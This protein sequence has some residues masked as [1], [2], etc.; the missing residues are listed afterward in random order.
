MKYSELFSINKNFQYSV[1][2]EFDLNNKKKIEEYIPTTDICDVLKTYVK[3]V[4][5]HSKDKATTLVGPY[6]KGKSFLLL[7]LSYILEL[8]DK[9]EI[10]KLLLDKIKFIDSELYDLI[11][12]IDDRAIKLLPV[13]INSNYDNV[14]QSFQLALNDALKRNKLDDIIPKTVYDVCTSLLNKWEKDP[15][16]NNKVLKTCLE[17]NKIDIKDLKKGLKYFSV[18]AYKK[19]EILYNCVNI[20]LEFNP[21][22]SNDIVKIYADV[23]YQLP[24][25]GY[26]GLFIIF[27]EFSKFLDGTSSLMRD[28]KIIQDFAEL[29]DRSSKNEQIHLCCVT[30]KSFNLYQKNKDDSVS[31]AFKTVEGRFKEIKFN[32][33]LEENYQIISYAIKRKN[34]DEIVSKYINDNKDFYSEIMNLKIVSD[35]KN[36]DILINGCFPLNP[37]TVYSLIQLSEIVAQNERT[38]FTFLSDTDANSFNSFIH[39]HDTGLFNV[40]KIYDYFSNLLRKEETNYIRNIWYRCESTLSKLDDNVKRSIIKTI[41]IIHMINDFEKLSPSNEIIALCLNM[42]VEEIKIHID[43]LMEIRLIKRNF[44]NNLLSFAS[45]NSKEIEEEL[46]KVI[47]GKVKNIR[48]SEIADEINEN[49]YLLPRRYNEQNKITRFFKVIFL[50]DSE[51]IDLINFDNLMENLYCDGIVIYLIKRKIS[52]KEIIEKMNLINDDRVIVKYPVEKVD[53]FFVDELVKFAGLKEINSSGSI[54]DIVSAEINLILEETR[55]DIITLINN[56]F[57]DNCHYYH[58]N[59]LELSFNNLLSTVM[60]NIY[61]RI[62]IFNNELINKTNVSAQYQKSIN[63]VIDYLINFRTEFSFSETSPEMTIYN[64]VILKSEEADIREAINYIKNFIIEAEGTKNSIRNIVNYLN[65]RPFGIRLGI[66]PILIG[67]AINELSDNV[68]LYFQNKEIDLTPENIVKSVY[69]ENDKYAF[70]FARGSKEQNIYLDNLMNLFKVGK[71]ENFRFDINA[72]ADRIRKWFIGLPQIIRS[73]NAS[74]N[75]LN[76]SDEIL[77]LKYAYMSFNINPYE[78]VFTKPLKLFKTNN[79]EQVYNA[80]LDFVENIDKVLLTYKQKL[81]I[82]LKPIFEVTNDSSLKTGINDWLVKKINLK[83]TPILEGIHRKI[84]DCLKDSLTYDDFQ[85][86]DQVAKAALN[87]YIEDWDNDRSE[88]LIAVMSEFSKSISSSKKINLV[89]KNGNLESILNAMS[90]ADETQMGQLLTNSLDSIFEEYSDSVS[91]EEKL[92]ILSRIIKKLL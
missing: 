76:F 22:I 37:L 85:S 69:S 45:S 39:N 6:G 50:E 36:K 9:D 16:L 14:S 51:F 17:K 19:F 32:R 29:A 43:S 62:V 27:D 58:I 21:L 74:N 79:Y 49:K 35:E 46:K 7:V 92:A 23:A 15:D 89:S 31:N 56:Y 59:R 41:A 34:A 42:N 64:S 8:K 71:T 10:Y 26:T 80:I 54:D 44:I 81:I 1:N 77:E 60:E 30:H 13:I 83:E 78:V 66:I 61:T 67:K 52:N 12:Q 4:L 5:G 55:N 24:K 82:M 86:L 73:V 40:N 25:F 3:S 48:I 38:L 70:S 33:S 63:N 84:F 2:I 68:L 28:L 11:N 91:N 88:E 18:N 65:S 20:G 75:Y 57:I 87:L 47:R 53:K 72:T 90:K